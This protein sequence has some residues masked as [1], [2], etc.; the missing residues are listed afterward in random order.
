MTTGRSWLCGPTLG[1]T[2]LIAL[3]LALATAAA[4]SKPILDCGDAKNQKCTECG[5]D[6][7]ACCHT[8][9]DTI[10]NP[11]PKTPVGAIHA[12]VSSPG[13]K[14]T[15]ARVP[16]SDGSAQFKLK[17]TLASTLSSGSFSATGLLTGPDAALAGLLYPV[18]FLEMGGAA[19]DTLRGDGYD[20]SFASG[21]PLKT[22]Q[23]VFSAPTCAGLA[24]QLARSVDT[25]L[26][27][28]SPAE[29]AAFVSG[30]Q[31]I[32]LSTCTT[33]TTAAP[34]TTTTSTTTVQTTTTTI[35]CRLIASGAAGVCGGTCPPGQACLM[36][37]PNGST[38]SCHPVMHGCSSTNCSGAC[39]VQFERC[40]PT[41][42][43]QCSCCTLTG[44]L[45][46]TASV[47]CS[48]QPCDTISGRCVAATTST[49]TTIATS[50]SSLTSTTVIT[51]T[52][53]T[54]PGPTTTTTIPCQLVPSGAAGVCGGT[55]PS[56]Q[57]CM[58]NAPN[59]STCSCQPD[60]HACSSTNCSG[61][62]SV[63]FQRC[64]PNGPTSCGCCTLTGDFCSTATVCCSGQ[65]CDT[66]SGRC[67]AAPTTTTTPSPTT[68]TT[69][70]PTTTTTSST[71]STT[72]PSCV[73]QGGACN[74]S[75]DCCN[76]PPAF[77]NTSS[78]P[79]FCDILQ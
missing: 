31:A 19:L 39:S 64:Q 8:A 74:V 54:T 62:C 65:P 14:L 30:L 40:Q 13:A 69:P 57:T 73:A 76:A 66:V 21:P 52:T 5:S 47:C 11:P 24:T 25:T 70:S 38:C 20:F 22:C 16:K 53:T 41:G 61:N 2:A 37:A 67:P 3:A 48:G 33:T 32:G 75:S 58:M 10:N 28:T 43:A 29:R 1:W 68:T 12:T 63:Q 55:R 34:T 50:T 26:Q 23:D 35:P 59:G 27:Y 71:T 56:G 46:S 72:A 60:M 9:C 51:T 36:N 45:C 49:S 44:D 17:Q 77:C 18:A 7:L 78:G 4:Q 15:F 79:G 6:G 42:P